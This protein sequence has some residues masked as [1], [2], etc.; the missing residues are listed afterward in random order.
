MAAQG[1]FDGYAGMELEFPTGEI[2]KVKP[3]SLERAAHWLRLWERHTGAKDRPSDPEAKYEI[4]RD[5][6]KE[7]GLEAQFA[8]LTLEE[9]WDVFDCF[10]GRRKTR[11]PSVPT[12]AVTTPPSPGTTS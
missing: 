1:F 5:F 12:P 3:L 2:V 6:P 7:V 9:F 10:F 11:P 8:R 4:F